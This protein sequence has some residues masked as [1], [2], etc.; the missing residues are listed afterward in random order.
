MRRLFS[1]I[2]ALAATLS[3]GMVQADFAGFEI[4]APDVVNTNEAIDIT[5]R[6]LDEDGNVYKDYAGTM[7][8]DVEGDDDAI[9][10][11]I[12]DGYTFTGA[13]EGVHTFSKAI[14]FK[15]PG[16]VTVLVIDIDDDL[17]SVVE[18][19]ITVTE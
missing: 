19:S 2:L 16:Q 1:S 4:D 18:K 6:A 17:G 14:T 8:F 13:D 9:I 3:L 5:V 10:P 15:N 7:F 11:N 12:L